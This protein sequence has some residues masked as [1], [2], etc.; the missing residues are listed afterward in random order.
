MKKSFGSGFIF[1][2]LRNVPVDTVLLSDYRVEERFERVVR[3]VWAALG[4]EIVTRA[5]ILWAKS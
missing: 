1:V 2:W 4:S 3:R 5:S